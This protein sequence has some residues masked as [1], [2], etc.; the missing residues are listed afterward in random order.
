MGERGDMGE[1]S[2]MGNRGDLDDRGD[3]TDRGDGA[4]RSDRANQAD[5]ASEYSY[6]SQLK[7]GSLTYSL[8]GLTCRD[9]SASKKNRKM[10]VFMEYVCMSGL[11]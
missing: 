10:L 5:R 11:N 4:D 9:A 8:T 6:C 1:S 2:D 3:G 7:M